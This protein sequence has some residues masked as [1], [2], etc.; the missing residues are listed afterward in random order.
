[1]QGNT[2]AWDPEGDGTFTA[3]TSERTLAYRY[4]TVGTYFPAVR[5]IY[6]DGQSSVATLQLTVRPYTIEIDPPQGDFVAGVADT[7]LMSYDGSKYGSTLAIDW[8]LDGDGTF[9][10]SRGA[11]LLITPLFTSPGTRTVSIRATRSDGSYDIGHRE[12]TVEP[13]PPPGPTGISINNGARYTND[14]HV[15]LRVTW[16]SGADLAWVDNDGG[17]GTAKSFPVASMLTWTLDSSGPERLPKTVYARFDDNVTTFQDDIILDETR[18]TISTAT[19]P[20]STTMRATAGLYR[21]RIKAKDTTSGVAQVQ[22]AR[23][24]GKPMSPMA[25]KRTVRVR[26][27][28]PPRFVRVIDAAGNLSQ[29]KRLASS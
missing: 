28:N 24:K 23:K 15:S 14:P 10:Y 20:N 3:P 11:M 18:P 21:I 2:Y 4:N 16:L 27:A 5:V 12:I 8:D 22:F 19:M 17:F 25:Y 6:Q 1:M 13:A 9:E 7:M 29:W 26:S